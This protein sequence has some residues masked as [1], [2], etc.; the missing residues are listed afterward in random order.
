MSAPDESEKSRLARRHARSVGVGLNPFPSSSPHIQN[1]QVTK[2]ETLIR[3]SGSDSIVR[4][5][6]IFEIMTDLR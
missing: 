6:F 2:G 4:G 3:F 1:K 5:L